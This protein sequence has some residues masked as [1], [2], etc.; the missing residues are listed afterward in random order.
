MKCM[1]LPGDVLNLLGMMS[2]TDAFELIIKGLGL[3]ISRQIIQLHAG[4]IWAQSPP[5]DKDMGSTFHFKI[6]VTQADDKS[7]AL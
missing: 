4:E 5:Q 7:R 2:L 3:P 1:V 6:P